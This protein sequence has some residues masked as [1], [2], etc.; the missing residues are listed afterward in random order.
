M[1]PARRWPRPTG[2]GAAL[3]EG[4]VATVDTTGLAAG[5]HYIL[6][7]GL[8]DDGIWG[9]FTAVFLYILEPGV[10]PVLE[11][12]VREAASNLPLDATVT[13]GAFVD[14]TDPATGYYSMTV[15]SGTY[16]VSAIAASHVVSTVTGIVAENYQTVQQDF[17]LHPIC[18]AFADDVEIGQP[19]WTAQ[20]PWAITTESSH[21]ATHSWTDS[22]G[23]NYSQQPEHLA[24]LAGFRPV[25]LHRGHAQL[26]AHV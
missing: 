11:G 6:V 10:S 8:N 12:Y 13:A 18:D 25:R 14:T 9:P 4:V 21:S 5:R 19:G 22:P 17:Y 3:S 24:H 15:I 16:D 26:L 1:A 20:T 23:G 7:H 2:H